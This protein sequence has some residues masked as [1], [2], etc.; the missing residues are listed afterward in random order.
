MTIM[1][2]VVAAAA[3]TMM[4]KQWNLCMGQTIMDLWELV[5]PPQDLS[6]V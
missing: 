6:I 5:F 1:V 4:I 3:T 2:V